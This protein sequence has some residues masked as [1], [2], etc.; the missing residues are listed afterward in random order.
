MGI[1]G[2]GIAITR[3]E[4]GENKNH[5]PGLSVSLPHKMDD[6]ENDKKEDGE[7]DREESFEESVL[8]P[9]APEDMEGAGIRS[10]KNQSYGG[11]WIRSLAFTIDMIL[12]SLIQT[13]FGGAVKLGII[14]GA[15]IL[16]MNPK[17]LLDL[18]E[19]LI[20]ICGVAIMA[21]YFIYFHGTT[22][23]TPGKKVCGLKVIKMAGG[24]LGFK[25]STVRFFSYIVSALPLY[26]GFILVAFQ[27][28][29]QGLH[30][31][32]TRTYVIK[33]KGHRFSKVY[34]NSP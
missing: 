33:T 18:R 14:T 16:E 25:E 28:K 22:G 26:F 23:Q 31:L 24:P 34:H 6:K 15:G 27:R 21:F 4:A 7:E 3:Q 9:A 13:I 8:S 1:K 10:T 20:T 2:D 19:F 29:K 17:T 11:F 12:I 30:D 5:S 32:I